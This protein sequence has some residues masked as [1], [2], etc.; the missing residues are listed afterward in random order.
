MEGAVRQHYVPRFIIKNW[1]N[2]KNDVL[3]HNIPYDKFDLVTP[4]CIFYKKMFYEMTLE[5]ADTFNKVEKSLSEMEDVFSKFLAAQ[6]DKDFILTGEDVVRFKQFVTVQLVRSKDVR[7]V[8]GEK[9]ELS[10]LYYFAMGFPEYMISYMRKAGYSNFYIEQIVKKFGNGSYYKLC[11]D[12]MRGMGIRILKAEENTFPFLLYDNPV[13]VDG[14]NLVNHNENIEDFKCIFPI[15]PQY[16]IGVT[17][18]ECLIQVPPRIVSSGFVVDV[19]FN[20]AGYGVGQRPRLVCGRS[21]DKVF[22]ESIR[23]V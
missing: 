6:F 2:D 20:L 22:M 5:N 9:N 1:C 14:K 21:E 12:S 11:F 13:L 15:H 8:Y 10:L 17:R 16:A 7:E 4:N 23:Y 3:R 18:K 19:N